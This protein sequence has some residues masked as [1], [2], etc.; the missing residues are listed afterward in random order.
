LSMQLGNLLVTT[1]GEPMLT[2]LINT[3]ETNVG[4]QEI[5]MPYSLIVFLTW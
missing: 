3:I 5:W 1:Q 4:L 2:P